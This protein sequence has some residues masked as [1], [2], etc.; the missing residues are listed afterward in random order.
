MKEILFKRAEINRFATGILFAIA[1]VS[2]FFVSENAAQVSK[3]KIFAKKIAVQKTVPAP[4]ANAPKVT[5]IDAA[6]L[7]KLLMRE[8][9][10]SK[11]LLV[12]FWATWCGPCVEEFPDLVKITNDYKDKID[13]IAVTLD[14]LAEIDRDVPAFLTKMKATMPN[15]LLKT[16]DDEEAIKVVA[17][18]WKGG[19][20]FTILYDGKGIAVYTRQGKFVPAV[21]RRTIDTAVAQ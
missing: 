7:K 3:K 16:D 20:P 13:V 4:T 15:Y 9:E 12:N 18:S 2:A 14:D 11:P 17:E 10:N 21:L 1:F 8:G 19:L 5:Q 6:A